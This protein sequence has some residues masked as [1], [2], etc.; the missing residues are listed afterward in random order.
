[1][2]ACFLVVVTEG[3]CQTVPLHMCKFVY[4]D[5]EESAEDVNLDLKTMLISFLQGHDVSM[6]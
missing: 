4:V 2:S 3:N 6:T 1:M 5:R